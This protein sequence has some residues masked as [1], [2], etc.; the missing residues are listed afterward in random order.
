MTDSR[1]ARSRTRETP[2]GHRCFAAVSFVAAVLFST[3]VATGQTMELDELTESDA[4]RRGLDRGAL[5]EVLDGQE[6]AAR[7]D[8]TAAA[9]WPNPTAAYAHEQTPGQLG[10]SEDYA[11]L[12]QRLDLSGR[13][14]LRVAAAEKR[15]R[16]ATSAGVSRRLEIAAEI[17]LRFFAVLYHQRRLAALERWASNVDE[18]T[19]VVTKRHAAGDAAGYDHLRI[20]VEG[21]AAEVEVSQEQAALALV[22]ERLAAVTGLAA[23][24]VRHGLRVAGR[25]LP[26]APM[27][28]VESLL[29]AVTTR[30][31]IQALAARTDAADDE[32]RAAARWWIPE[33]LVGGGMKSVEAGGERST[34]FTALGEIPL[35]LFDRD[36]PRRERAQAELMIARGELELERSKAGGEIRGL[37][38]QASTLA[39]A[40]SAAN[41]GMADATQLATTAEAG[42]RGGELGI[43]ELLDAERSVTQAE[44]RVIELE[45]AARAARVELDRITGGGLP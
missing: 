6:E 32:I 4:V 36:Q 16:A 24:A 19:A 45:W 1:I 37:H 27:P 14:G 42:Y 23:A 2:M 41:S 25:L 3:V 22:R 43:I 7:S 31:D 35:P 12:A 34:G 39:T 15:V 17:R 9:L 26:E 38:R 29:E 13:R 33:V 8:L 11:W 10:S 28:A 5:R 40:A 44:L 21:D 18:V 20:G 30:P